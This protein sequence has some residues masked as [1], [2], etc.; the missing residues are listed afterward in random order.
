MFLYSWNQGSETAR[1]LARELG[2]RRIRHDNST[3]RGNLNKVV[4]NYG[5]SSLPEEVLKC[6]VVNDPQ[7]V[8]VC[9]NKLSFFRAVSE[10]E[11]CPRV[12]DWTDQ[13]AVVQQWF[14]EGYLIVARTVLQGHSGEGIVLFSNQDDTLPNDLVNARLY[15]KYVKKKDE[16][17]VHIVNG[18]VIDFARK[19]VRNDFP[20]EM[21]NYRIRNYQNGYVYVRGGVELP[22]DVSSQALLAMNKVGLDFGAVDVIYN[23]RQDRAY[24]LEINTAPGM[25]GTT[26]NSYSQAL[27]AFVRGDVS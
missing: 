14:L 11:D 5:S 25:E 13:R 2:A 26:L 10:G 16:Y 9:S 6:R 3:F 8:G 24:V 15:T 23:E 19:A 20:E 1:L 12:P 27:T 17:R 21:R 22:Q 4:I 7:A 18:Q